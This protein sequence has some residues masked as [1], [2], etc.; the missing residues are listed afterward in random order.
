MQFR[1]FPEP[2][3]ADVTDL[4]APHSYDALILQAT[5]SILGL[6]LLLAASAGTWIV[7]SYIALF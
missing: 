6:W 1:I 7:S 5:R 3:K 2:L 4:T